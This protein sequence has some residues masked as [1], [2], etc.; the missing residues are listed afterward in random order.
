MLFE[1]VGS[2]FEK[3]T[4]IQNKTVNINKKRARYL[5]FSQQHL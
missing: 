4:K 5:G 3:E 2:W 1:K